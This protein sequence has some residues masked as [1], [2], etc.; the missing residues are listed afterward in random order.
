MSL[1]RP[2]P[3]STPASPGA[4]GAPHF[5]A[6]LWR[7]LGPAAG[8]IEG[9]PK[10]YQRLAFGLAVLILVFSAA[11]LFNNLTGRPNKDYDLWYQVG[12]DYRQGLDIYPTDARPFPFMYPPA[13]AALL[14]V[15]TLAGPFGF[16]ALLV[17]A[18]SAAWVGSVF[19]SV[20]LATGASWR[21]RPLLYAGPTLW[22]VPFVHDMYLLGQ[23][24]LFLLLLMLGAFAGLRRGRPWAAGALVGLAA[25]IKAFPVLALG[26]FVYRRQWKATASAALTLALLLTVAPLPFRGA[27]RAARELVV[28]TKG[29]VLRYDEGQIAQRPERCYS[30]KN[31]SLVGVANRLLRS[32]PADGESKDP[33][34]VN[35]ADLGFRGVNRVIAGLTAALGLFYVGVMRWRPS[36]D[37][38]AARREFT[39]ETAMLL[40]MVLV[41][42]PF[43][44]NYFYVWLIYPLTVLIARMNAA[45]AGSAER[46]VLL[47]GLLVSLAVF[48]SALVSLRGA[49]A[50]GNLLLTDFLLLGLLGWLLLRDRVSAPSPADA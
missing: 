20:R 15:A 26:Y 3:A 48:A 2:R 1:T 32:V 13:A 47:A 23:P 31:Q 43:A 9:D 38:A 14:A 11:P 44:F 5:R 50:Y 42:S 39:A 45:P 36:A 19:L 49:Q 4:P 7:R 30:F 41:F 28:W 40:L 37:P 10:V 46:R 17:L 33:W 27:S 12:R 18:N 29:M 22:V 24:N 16:V 25:A 6:P 34:T 8:R 35:V 21:Q